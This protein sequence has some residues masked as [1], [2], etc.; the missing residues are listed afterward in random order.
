MLGPIYVSA[1]PHNRP[2]EKFW[3][4]LECSEVAC[5]GFWT[6]CSARWAGEMSQVCFCNKAEI[7]NKEANRWIVRASNIPHFGIV[8]P[9]GA[10]PRYWFNFKIDF[11]S[12]PSVT[13]L[14]MWAMQGFSLC[15][16]LD[17][18][19]AQWQMLMVMIFGVGGLKAAKESVV[20]FAGR[21]LVQL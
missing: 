17:F 10:Y 7:Q 2:Q 1:W 15:F 6:T 4:L 16:N 18:S 8:V 20:V 12:N 5:R 14:L 9:F 19:H 21:S 11:I 3:N 13:P